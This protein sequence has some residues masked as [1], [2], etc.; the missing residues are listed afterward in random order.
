MSATAWLQQSECL[1]ECDGQGRISAEWMLRHEC[2]GRVPRAYSMDLRECRIVDVLVENLRS[3]GELYILRKC[4]RIQ[5]KCKRMQ[6][7]K[8][9]EYR[10]LRKPTL[11]SHATIVRQNTMTASAR[12]RTCF[13]RCRLIW[14]EIVFLTISHFEMQRTERVIHHLLI[15]A[16]QIMLESIRATQEWL[17]TS[18]LRFYFTCNFEEQNI[19][20]TPIFRHIRTRCVFVDIIEF[21]TNKAFDVCIGMSMLFWL[22]CFLKW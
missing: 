12:H 15:I 10:A 21:A 7:V 14:K 6:G 3:L 11:T 2:C 19:P 8:T 17:H 13:K 1:D 9:K 20:F 16:L 4:K 5:V 18:S 22:G